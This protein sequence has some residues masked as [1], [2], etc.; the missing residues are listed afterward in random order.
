MGCQMHKSNLWKKRKVLF[1]KFKIF[2]LIYFSI[3]SETTGKFNDTTN[4]RKR[5]QKAKI[6]NLSKGNSINDSILKVSA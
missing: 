1:C 4:E 3:D 5:D 6:K 2:N